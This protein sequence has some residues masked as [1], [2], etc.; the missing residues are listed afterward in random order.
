M[1]ARRLVRRTLAAAIPLAV[2]AS[3]ALPEIAA[4]RPQKCLGKRATIT[5]TPAAD[6]IS[7]TRGTDV[8][9]GLGGNDIIL[10]H[11]GKDRICGSAGDDFVRAGGAEDV[12][13]GGVGNDTVAGDLENDSVRGGAGND[14]VYGG[15]GNDVLRAG[16]GEA[17]IMFGNQGRDRLAGG[18]GFDTLLGL[19][20]N[21]V[22]DGGPGRFDIA[23]FLFSDNPDGVIA[24]LEAD[25][26]TGEGEDLIPRIETLEGSRF[27]DQLFGDAEI[28]VFYPHAGDDNVVGAGGNDVLSFAFSD[29]GVTAEMFPGTATGEGE[30]TF[31]GIRTL[32]G[33]ERPDNFTGDLLDNVLD[34]EQGNDTL[35][36]SAG[37]DVLNGGTG[38]DTGDGG[39]QVQGD[40]CISIEEPT[41]CEIG[42]GGGGGGGGTP[43]DDLLA[44]IEQTLEDLQEML[45]PLPPPPP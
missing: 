40:R 14:I 10:G 38:T 8:I 19:A 29:N 15:R 7:G 41:D 42:G 36:G 45:P 16:T 17:S 18:D 33:S 1:N 20:G 31:S 39:L 22:I 43:L 9:D 21:D 30:D 12:V 37:D 11:T 13:D 27:G 34:G 28:N 2:A 3:L 25:T 23:S 32:Q 24:D 6:R 4:A 5:G 26:A 44:E 35:A